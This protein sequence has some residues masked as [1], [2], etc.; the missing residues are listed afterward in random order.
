MGCSVVYPQELPSEESCCTAVE[1]SVHR[2]SLHKLGSGVHPYA[3]SSTMGV[4][5]ASAC[6]QQVTDGV[7]CRL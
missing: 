7:R 3:R 1:T 4:N 5:L 6:L 2:P